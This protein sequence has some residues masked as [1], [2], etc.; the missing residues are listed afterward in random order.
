MKEVRFAVAVL[1]CL[2]FVIF[3]F[4]SLIPVSASSTSLNN[5]QIFVQTT[6][7]N[8]TSYSLTAYN[9]SGYQIAFSTSTYLGFG[10]ELP[11]GTYLITV[12]ATH[13]GSYYPITYSS[14]SGV[15]TSSTNSSNAPISLPIRVPVTEYGYTLQ[16]INAPVTLNIRTAPLSNVP[17]NKI[18]VS[19]SYVNGTGAA[20]VWIYGSVVSGYYYDGL[21]TKAVMENQTVTGGSTTLI[22]PNLPV[23]LNG[24]IS[25]PVNVHKTITTTTTTI[26]GQPVNITM[27]WQPNYVELSGTA[28][29]IPP[30]T[31]NHMI[32]R[33]QQSNYV[34]EPYAS[35]GVQSGAATTITSTVPTGVE[36]NTGNSTA[37]TQIPPFEAQLG[38]TSNTSTIA[39]GPA[40]VNLLVVGSI[41]LIIALA[42]VAG[43]AL[44][45]VR[46]P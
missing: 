31:T 28:L 24:Y 12:T 21:N 43:F 35:N 13:Q 25:L 46:K 42:T 14:G 40:S 39:T 34:I 32:L 10:L 16:T 44:F 19:V 33:V 41:V 18:Q 20:G 30:Q 45:R 38:G 7:T 15:A 3:G 8:M 17:T 36:S 9:S 6:N 5:I 22:V 4:S 37:P 23:L 1:V 29:V 2:S 26:G 11:S 27:Y